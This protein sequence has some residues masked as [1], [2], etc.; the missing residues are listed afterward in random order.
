MSDTPWGP[1]NQWSDAMVHS[2]LLVEKRIQLVGPFQRVFFLGER[3][4]GWSSGLVRRR[5]P[6]DPPAAMLWTNEL[7]DDD[8]ACVLRGLSASHYALARQPGAYRTFVREKLLRQLPLE[9]V[10]TQV[11]SLS[12]NIHCSFHA[13]SN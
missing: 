2:G 5:V 6:L 7:M 3:V 8:L 4:L 9:G 11:Y 13:Y 12:P 10:V 1:T